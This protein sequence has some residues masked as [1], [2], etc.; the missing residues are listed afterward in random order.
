VIVG[1]RDV[2]TSLLACA[3]AAG[4]FGGRAANLSTLL[5]QAAP[6]LV[7][8]AAVLLARTEIS[9]VVQNKIL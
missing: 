8:L 9:H 2:K 4:S 7:V 1:R 5:T 6:G 3:V